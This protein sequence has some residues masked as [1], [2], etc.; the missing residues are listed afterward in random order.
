M[1]A[2]GSKVI[3]IAPVTL[4]SGAGLGYS[5]IGNVLANTVGTTIGFDQSWRDGN[6]WRVDF[7]IVIGWAHATK[8]QEDVA[9]PPPPPPPPPVPVTGLIPAFGS[10]MISDHYNCG[11]ADWIDP[12]TLPAP[13]PFTGWHDP[14]NKI[15]APSQNGVRPAK[16]RR[17]PLYG[18][19][20]GLYS[21]VPM[22]QGGKHRQW[23]PEVYSGRDFA[24]ITPR[25]TKDPA[26]MGVRG[27]CIVDP[28]GVPRPH[29]Q[30]T[31]TN[32]PRAPLY[33]T[34][35]PSGRLV[36]ELPEKLVSA[37]I[38]PGLKD[39]HDFALDETNLDHFYVANTGM[40]TVVEVD[41]RPAIAA[42][43][44]GGVEDASLYV[45]TVVASGFQK[46]TSVEVMQDGSLYACDEA[47]GAVY[48]FF[49][50]TIARVAVASGLVRPF[51]IRRTSRGTLLIATVH[52]HVYEY[53][54][55]TGLLSPNKMPAQYL[56]T[57]PATQKEWTWIGVDEAGTL[58]PKDEFW[59]CDS[60]STNNVAVWQFRNDGSVLF[61]AQV[62]GQQST[63]T[64]GDN[65]H[66]VEW[67]HYFWTVVPHTSQALLRST[68]FA[69]SFPT[70]LRAPIPSDAPEEPHDHALYRRGEEV[71]K[72]GTAR[73]MPADVRPSLTAL[74]TPTGASLLG[75]TPDWMV[76]QATLRDWLWL[77]TYIQ[78][79]MGGTTKR[80]ELVGRDLYGLVYCIVKSSSQYLTQGATLW[81]SAKAYFIGKYGVGITTN[82]GNWAARKMDGSETFLRASVVSGVVTVK[83]EDKWGNP[84]LIVRGVLVDVIVD[85]GRPGESRMQLGYPWSTPITLSPGPHAITCRSS[86]F[87][88]FSYGVTV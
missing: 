54:P 73:S 32:N 60:S 43:P 84:K 63:T 41:R 20:T 42:R 44:P 48:E 88:H 9:A 72:Y 45:V 46:V 75:I 16:L 38:I 6:F 31:N 34:L 70:Y 22:I 12:A 49:P 35:E 83:G 14:A 23:N 64:V 66:G 78:N 11:P 29:P 37:G 62:M 7:G 55:A 1:I 87:N 36:F 61:N 4:Y 26:P 8:L 40:G 47:A 53:D 68:G 5:V 82:D 58:G 51:C 81:N 86:S 25:V 57:V 74:M 59:V 18:N 76:Q 2:I 79:G 39:P 30:P 80:P 13:V 28:Y 77:E 65:A 15:I 56:R 69:N 52:L 24:S 17:I 3:T 27:Q 19:A 10:S 85:E 33:V 71:I 50:Q 21:C 67:S